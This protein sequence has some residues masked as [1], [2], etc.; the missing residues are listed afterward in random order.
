MTLNDLVLGG[1]KLRE[2]PMPDVKAILQRSIWCK[3]WDEHTRKNE[4]VV[5]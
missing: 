3:E 4:L 2:S 1:G 5:S